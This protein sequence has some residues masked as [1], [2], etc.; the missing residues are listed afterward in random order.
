MS[1]IRDLKLGELSS[2]AAVHEHDPLMSPGH[3]LEEAP[4]EKPK[5]VGRGGET[6]GPHKTA[7]AVTSSVGAVALPAIPVTQPPPRPVSA[8]HAVRAD[9]PP[10]PQTD[11]EAGCQE[12]K[13]VADQLPDPTTPLDSTE[14]LAQ[15]YVEDAIADLSG[16]PHEY[17]SMS[18]QLEGKTYTVEQRGDKMRVTGPGAGKPEVMKAVLEMAKNANLAKPVDGFEQDL[19]DKCIASAG[20]GH[21]TTYSPQQQQEARVLAEAALFRSGFVSSI[22]DPDQGEERVRG[23]FDQMRVRDAANRALPPRRG[24]A[25]VPQLPEEVRGNFKKVIRHLREHPDDESF[26]TSAARQHLG[27]Q[28]AASQPQATPAAVSRSG[29]RPAPQ[30]PIRGQQE[31]YINAPPGQCYAPTVFRGPWRDRFFNMHYRSALRNPEDH[32]WQRFAYAYAMTLYTRTPEG[33]EA[34]KENLLEAQRTGEMFV[35]RC[36]SLPDNDAVRELQLHLV[37]LQTQRQQPPPRRQHI[38]PRE[39]LPATPAGRA[40]S[41][42]PKET[43]LSVPLQNI[44]LSPDFRGPWQNETFVR[45]FSNF[46][47]RPGNESQN[48]TQAYGYAMA[49]HYARCAGVPDEKCEAFGTHISQEFSERTSEPDTVV[50]KEIAK[51]IQG[52]PGAAT[53]FAHSLQQAASPAEA[54]PPSK[55]V[56]LPVEEAEAV[57]LPVVAPQETEEVEVQEAPVPNKDLLPQFPQEM[58]E[59]PEFNQTFTHAFEKDLHRTRIAVE[60]WNDQKIAQFSFAYAAYISQGIAENDAGSLAHH[61]VDDLAQAS[62]DGQAALISRLSSP[63]EHLQQPPEAQPFRARSPFASPPEPVV[64]EGGHGLEQET[65]LH[66]LLPFQFPTTYFKNKEFSEIYQRSLNDSEVTALYSDNP[67]KAQIFAFAFAVHSL[68]FSTQSKDQHTIYAKDAVERFS[69][70]SDQLVAVGIP[71]LTDLPIADDEDMPEEEMPIGHVSE[72]ALPPHEGLPTDFPLARLGDPKFA[73]IYK[74]KLYDPRAFFSDKASAPAFAFAYAAYITQHPLSKDADENAV[75]EQTTQA[76]NFAREILGQLETASEDVRRTIISQLATPPRGTRHFSPMAQP[77]DQLGPGHKVD[78]TP[79]ERVLEAEDEDTIKEL[80]EEAPPQPEQLEPGAP[81]ETEGKDDSW[82]ELYSTLPEDFR[83]PTAP[84]DTYFREA[85]QIGLKYIN[86]SDPSSDNDAKKAFAYAFA[87]SIASDPK[88]SQLF[89]NFIDDGKKSSYKPPPQ[90]VTT[91]TLFKSDIKYTR[92]QKERNGVIGQLF[93]GTLARSEPI[94][95]PELMK[96]PKDFAGPWEDN[97]FIHLYSLA[98]KDIS[99]QDF[100]IE[101]RKAYAYAYATCAWKEGLTPDESA[102]SPPASK[103]ARAFMEKIGPAKADE[104]KDLISQ[105]LTSSEQP[106]EEIPELKPQMLAGGGAGTSTYEKASPPTKHFPPLSEKVQAPPEDKVA[107]H[108][109]SLHVEN[110]V[111]PPPELNLP[112]DFMGPWN[113]KTFLEAFT[114]GSRDDIGKLLLTEEEKKAFAFA[115]AAFKTTNKEKSIEDIESFALNRAIDIKDAKPAQRQAIVAKLFT[116]KP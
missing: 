55:P 82:L 12:V 95:P 50:Q 7:K 9:P 102:F 54:H 76:G 22:G 66:D 63:L 79:E 33:K 68:N 5:Q 37:P 58:F 6:R 69:G 113:D 109:E 3:P 70:T 8:D 98:F 105:L 19:F 74:E 65:P 89:K 71:T 93:G 45:D 26:Q 103:A 21:I 97:N 42:F 59:D 92:D 39:R 86:Q 100:S 13:R 23:C 62:P 60:K 51:L 43:D 106:L 57:P 11:I 78:L 38:P 32:Q 64:E 20:Q 94:P 52:L 101:E 15:E 10:I 90:A 107:Q 35:D 48:Y 87:V 81:E 40:A 47:H 44:Q 85:F 115:Y 53:R 114:E 83:T 116:P 84:A 24:D 46:L 80:T 72:P 56:H 108:G 75:R 91:A 104:R 31:E 61:F 28:P 49:M 2:M 25:S 29:P 14:T 96:L 112:S 17:P 110:A 88:T 73:A 30:A 67:S 1:R 77:S 36:R 41:P 18:V 111:A 99:I 4:Q 27:A 16:H 34:T